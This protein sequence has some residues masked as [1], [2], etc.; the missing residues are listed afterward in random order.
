MPTKSW[1]KW[2]EKRSKNE[3]K[4]ATVNYSNG[5]L[6]VFWLWPLEASLGLNAYTSEL[7][8]RIHQMD[9]SF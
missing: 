5:V 8:A 1:V 4:Q 9:H 3:Q 6:R 7:S 2:D